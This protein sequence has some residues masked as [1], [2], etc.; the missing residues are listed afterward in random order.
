[1]PA[2]KLS[3]MEMTTAQGQE[4]TRNVQARRIQSRQTAPTEA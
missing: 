4:M 3:G 1:M 2:K